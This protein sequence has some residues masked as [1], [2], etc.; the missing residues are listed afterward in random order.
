LR[1]TDWFPQ[2]TATCMSGFRRLITLETTSAI[3]ITVVIIMIAMPA[4]YC[5]R[6]GRFTSVTAIPMG[7]WFSC[8]P[9][10]GHTAQS[11]DIGVWHLGQ[12]NVFPPASDTYFP[13]MRVAQSNHR[14]CLII[15]IGIN[16]NQADGSGMEVAGRAHNARYLIANFPKV[17][18]G[19]S[20]MIIWL[21]YLIYLLTI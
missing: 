8:I 2:G 11:A 13:A 4:K 7:S 9:H 6:L 5:H 16:V 10:L 1:V 18:F 21:H 15:H 14:V 3:A 19:D 17:L 12:F 20:L